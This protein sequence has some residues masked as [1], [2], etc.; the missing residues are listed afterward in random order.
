M[1]EIGNLNC[2]KTDVMKKVLILVKMNVILM[3]I[4][5]LFMRLMNTFMER[6]I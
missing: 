5:I 2:L 3:R 1:I 4:E 6:N